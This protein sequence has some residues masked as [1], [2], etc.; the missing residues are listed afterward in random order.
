MNPKN[1]LSLLA[2]AM[3]LPRSISLAQTSN[4]VATPAIA[5]K[6][7][8]TPDPKHAISWLPG[9]T[10]EQHDARMAWLREAKFGMFI[11]WGLYCI[12][13]DGEWHMRDHK[14]PF[15][16]YSKLAAQFNPEKFDADQ[17][18]ELAHQAGMKYVVLTTKHH[19]GFAMFGSKASSYNVVDATPFKRDVVKELSQ[20]SPRH[21]VRFCAYYSF[22][23]DWGHPGGQAGCPHWDPKFQDGDKRA[24]VRDVALPQLKEIL[25]NYGPIGELWFDTDGPSDITP[26]ESKQVVEI[27]KT[28]P[29]VIVNPRLPGVKGDFDTGERHIPLIPK[30]DWEYCDIISDGRW[31]YTKNKARPLEKLLPIMVT[32]WG[33]GGNVLMNVGPSSEGLIPEDQVER[34]RQ[35]GDW[36]KVNGESIYGSTAGPFNWVPWGTATR[37][38]D[39]VYLQVF[40]WPKDGLLKVPLANK[41][42]KAWLLA[43]PEKKP[44]SITSSEG[45]ILVHVPEKAPDAVVS[46]VALKIEGD[47]VSAY[48]VTLNKP[49]TASSKQESGQRIIDGNSAPHWYSNATNGGFFELDLGKPE[50]FSTLRIGANKNVP[51]CNLESLAS[52]YKSHSINWLFL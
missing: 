12:P 42:T 1:F 17:W 46:V 35:F 19:D 41:V 18:M 37:K 25:S 47:P 36:M 29:K 2:I 22:L 49:V 24:Y 14:V 34:L 13:A 11:H 7:T 50:S 10:Q 15:S 52:G 38:G 39:V 4:A 45:R 33:K 40:E 3:I 30:G 20:A 16:E 5:A 21:G 48:S 32:A 9:E 27:V 43:D 6:A 44:L 26:E 8:P 23:A 51:K 31:G 28:N